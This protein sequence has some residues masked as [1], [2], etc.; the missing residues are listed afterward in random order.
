V[1]T[2]DD[3]GMKNVPPPAPVEPA[4][5]AGPSAAEVA[6][7]QK[8]QAAVPGKVARLEQRQRL[9]FWVLVG[10]GLLL[11]LGLLAYGIKMTHK[12]AGPL[13][14][15]TL[16]MAKLR[17]GLYD[18]VYNLRKGDQL[19]GFYEHFKAAHAGM[20][21]LQEEDVA[22]L[23]ALLAEADEAGL[24]GRS[25]ELEGVVTDLREMLDRKEKSLV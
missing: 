20:R 22:R 13:Y 12:V 21:G 6:A 8:C 10:A 1:V 17:D 23:R 24:A 3:S 9:I 14:K 5:P 4:A 11:A 15:V 25:P 18:T 16:Y 7:F 2:I 19:I